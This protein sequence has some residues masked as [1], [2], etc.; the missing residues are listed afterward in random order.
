M[1]RQMMKSKIHRATVT[2]ADLDYVG[3]IS[4]DPELM[5]R[6]DI[7]EFEQVHV[8]D[9]N[10]GARL[11]TYAMRGEPGQICI[12]GAAA[13]LVGVGDKVIIIT[14]ADYTDEELRCFRP[15]IVHVDADNRE[16]FLVA[17]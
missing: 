5:D 8:L 13:H 4:I 6:A 10:N 2:E 1:R 15:S 3:S 17:G 7:M 9:V 12:N 14:Y 16:T 11:I